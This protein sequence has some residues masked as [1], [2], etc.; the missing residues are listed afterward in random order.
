MRLSRRKSVI[1][2]FIGIGFVLLASLIPEFLD[3]FLIGA[4]AKGNAQEARLLL[5]LRVDPNTKAADPG[6][7]VVQAAYN[8]RSD[9]VKTLIAA[10]GNPNA[11]TSGGETALM[12][13]S[14][15]GHIGTIRT[16]VALGADP[17]LGDGN[18]QTPLTYAMGQSAVVSA[19]RQAGAKGSQ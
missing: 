8:G 18:G 17:N 11:H 15:H 3:F 4:A 19:L 7:A 9:I 16:L 10:G 14:A 5:G 13:A 1:I 12:Y 6:N 2:G